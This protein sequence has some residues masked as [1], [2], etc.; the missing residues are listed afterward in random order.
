MDRKVILYIGV[1]LDGFIAD[2]DGS[3]DWLSGEETANVNENTTQ[4]MS[5]YDELLK[6]IDTIIMGMTTYTQ[7]VTE[8][9]PD[10]WPYQGIKSYI[11]TSKQEKDKEDIFFVNRNVSDL[12]KKLKE[13]EGKDIWVVGGANIANQL[14]KDDLID[15]Y[16]ITTLPIILGDGIRLFEQGNKTISLRLDCV[17]QYG[18]T[19]LSI[20]SRATE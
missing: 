12:V 18:D 9:S 2:K 13:E 14:I 19:V 4:D 16:R 7:V 8:L 6:G 1:S 11:V 5:S 3:V 15:E 17:K 10:V 20:Y